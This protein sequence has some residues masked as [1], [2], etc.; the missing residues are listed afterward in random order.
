MRLVVP[1]EVSP[2]ALE[3]WRQDAPLVDFSGETMG[4]T[5]RIR[6]AAPPALDRAALL[7]AVK[8]RLEAILAQMSHWRPDSVLGAFNRAAPGTWTVLPGDFAQVMQAALAIAERSG[9]AFDPTIGALVNLWGYGPEP[10]TELPPDAGTLARAHAAAG[11]ARLA[12]EPDTRRLRQPG[13]LHLDFSGIAKGFAVDALGAVLHAH[14]CRHGLVEIGGELLGLGF[15]PDCDPWWVDLETPTDEAPPLRVALHQAAV[16]TSGDYVRGRHTIDPRTARPVEHAMAVSVL[17]G[18]AMMADGW[19]TALSVL[20]P[21]AMARL[22][23][24]EKLQ[25]RALVRT[26]SGI[27]EWIS[28]AL[29]A[30]LVDETAPA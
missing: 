19:A 7:G 9:G 20:A 12:F 14:G 27:R 8:A 6:L 22:A 17:H 24:D 5:W 23:L 10:A 18:S 13:G 1:A 3:G 26:D 2:S 29:A 25:V 21:P 16:A 28:P 11:F 30:L 15:R 4:T